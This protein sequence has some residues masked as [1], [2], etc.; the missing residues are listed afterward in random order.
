MVAVPISGKLISFL[1]NFARL[2]FL[3]FVHLHGCLFPR[4]GPD[5]S[6]SSSAAELAQN[7]SK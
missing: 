2:H 7:S 5:S 3:S 4:L 1:L 6:H